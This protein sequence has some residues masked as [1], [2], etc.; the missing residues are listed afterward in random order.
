[1]THKKGDHIQISPLRIIGYL[2]SHF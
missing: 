1:M 2:V